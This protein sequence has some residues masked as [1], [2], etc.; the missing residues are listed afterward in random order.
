MFEAL[1]II[2]EEF[3]GKEVFVESQLDKIRFYE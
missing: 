3:A 2:S 1:K